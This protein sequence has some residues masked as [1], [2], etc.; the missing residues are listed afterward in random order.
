MHNKIVSTILAILVAGT[1]ACAQSLSLDGT[2]E[3]SLSPDCPKTFSSTCKVPGIAADAEPALAGDMHHMSS[4]VTYDHVWYRKTFKSDSDAT[5]A[6]LHL[7]ARYNARVFLNG[8][9]IG[10]SDACCFSHVEFDLTPAFNFHGNN[11]LV[12]KVGSWNTASFPSRENKNEWWRTSR[13]PGIIDNVTVTLS[14]GIIASRLEA[15]PDMATRKVDVRFTICNRG[16]NKTLLRPQVDIVDKDGR[17]VVKGKRLRTRLEPGQSMD[18]T[19]TADADCLEPWAPGKEGNPVLYTAV[20]SD[21]GKVLRRERFGYRD[22][23]V[24]GNRLM[25]NGEPMHLRSENVAFYRT[26]ISWSQ[27]VLDPVWVRDFIRTAVQEYGFNHLRI[28]LGHA[29]SLWYDIADEE[30]LMLQDEWCFMHEKDPKGD[31]LLQTEKEFRLWVRENINHPSII[32]WDMENEGDVDLAD[33]CA[34]LKAYDPTRPWAE[35]DFDTQHRYEYSENI[36]PR[37][38]VEPDGKR[39]TT[40]LE[41]CRLW[42][43]PDGRLE[44]RESFKTS[45]T[46]SSWNV[47]YYDKDILERFQAAIHCDQGT[48]F[49]AAKVLAWAPFALLSGTVNGHDFFR[50][51]LADGLEPQRNLLVLKSLNERVGGS[52]LMLE[53]Q[54]YYK[55]RVSY[56]CGSTF[57]KDVVLWNDTGSDV[58]AN[59]EVR[60]GRAEDEACACSTSFTATIPAYDAVTLSN[61]FNLVLPEQAGEYCLGISVNGVRGPERRICVGMRPADLTMPFEGATCT[62]DHF[63]EGI[64]QNIKKR[65]IMVAD[66]NP[67][68]SI[69]LKNGEY[70]IK[71]TEYD[72]GNAR[73]MSV[74]LDADG[75]ETS[76]KLLKSKQSGWLQHA[77]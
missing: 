32:A 77:F 41:S 36:H 15:L 66:G 60:L 5:M 14:N 17:T 54:E 8:S 35:D 3:A 62:L 26:L 24:K 69:Q 45:R 72:T 70:V 53:A 49:R 13:C 31:D 22:I 71:F 25:V 33:L 46:A 39:P 59:V 68:D 64:P 56:P 29:A 67:I 65:I 52:F 47:F 50:G 2:W 74:T 38:Y 40:I 73:T 63:L 37:P 6:I 44:P 30:G 43:N 58:T 76:R 75:I 57:T 48:Y 11:E 18:F 4:E 20:L 23:Q 28:H 1:Y 19:F 51:N 55:Q 12:V 21:N 61:P 16:R 10:Y 9:E 42:I 7:R 34:E 27:L